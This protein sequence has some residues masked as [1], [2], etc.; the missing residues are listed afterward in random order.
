MAKKLWFRAKTYGWGWTPCS[1]EGWLVVLLFIAFEYWNFMRLDA[2]SHSNSDT[3]RPFIIQSFFAVIIM[4]LV[5]YV[6]GEK[7]GWR[8]GAKK[9]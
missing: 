3:L 6:K 9:D 4:I 7:P 8:W 1:W 2:V 5:S